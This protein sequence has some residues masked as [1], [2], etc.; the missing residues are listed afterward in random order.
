MFHFKSQRYLCDKRQ[1]PI[2]V[3]IRPED[4]RIFKAGVQGKQSKVNVAITRLQMM[5]NIGTIDTGTESSLFTIISIVR[6]INA[7][8]TRHILNRGIHRRWLHTTLNNHRSQLITSKLHQISHD[9]NGRIET[10]KREFLPKN[11][12]INNTVTIDVYIKQRIIAERGLAA[13]I[14]I[15]Q[16]A[17][18]LRLRPHLGIRILLRIENSEIRLIY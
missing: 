7:K 3:Q 12:H 2:Q 14:G 10:G 18:I 6:T 4:I 16:G 8:Q 17:I 1:P 11:I 5:F 13:C 9:L 15:P